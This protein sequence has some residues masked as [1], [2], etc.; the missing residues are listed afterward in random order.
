ML[1]GLGTDIVDVERMRRELRRADGGFRDTVFTP[2]ERDRC[3]RARCPEQSYA[4][5]FA[6]KEALFKAL[7]TAW[8]GGLRWSEVELDLTTG[9]AEA[10]PRLG[11]AE[12][13]L[14]LVGAVQQAASQ[15]G[16][17]GVHV[18]VSHTGQLAMAS[19]LL[20]T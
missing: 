8:Q 6:A 4:E 3:D 13:Q 1:A 20:E 5:C 18:T 9:P 14:R 16:V 17:R 7:G 19:V 10:Q 2:A 15:A 12:P 11:G